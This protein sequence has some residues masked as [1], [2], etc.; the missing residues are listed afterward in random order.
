MPGGKRL[1]DVLDTGPPLSYHPYLKSQCFSVF[2]Q[3]KGLEYD[4]RLNQSRFN[5]IHV[6]R[7]RS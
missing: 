7:N 6:G 3:K 4:P 5:D 1:G 2:F